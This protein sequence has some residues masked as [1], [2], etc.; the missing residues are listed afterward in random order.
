LKDPFDDSYNA[1]PLFSSLPDIG[2]AF[3]F[4]EAEDSYEAEEIVQR[5]SQD[6]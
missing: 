3:R 5:Q 4:V 6:V 1:S 2:P